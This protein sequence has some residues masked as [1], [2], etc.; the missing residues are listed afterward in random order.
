MKKLILFLLIIWGLIVV[1]GSFYAGTL[2]EK[3][4]STRDETTQTLKQVIPDLTKIDNVQ[5]KD[6][7]AIITYRTLND[8]TKQQE[9]D[10]K[11]LDDIGPKVLSAVKEWPKYLW[12]VKLIGLGF[13]VLLATVGLIITILKLLFK[14]SWNIIN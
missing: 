12:V 2:V 6:Q 8:E 1:S 9:L 4:K 14:V 5:L 3:V 13:G 7:K 11:V 10:P